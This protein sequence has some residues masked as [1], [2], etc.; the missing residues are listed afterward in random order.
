MNAHVNITAEA[1]LPVAEEAHRFQIRETVEPSDD[2]ESWF[3]NIGGI[4]VL[5]TPV[6]IAEHR[7]NVATL[8]RFEV[9]D[10]VDLH[11]TSRGHYDA[12]VLDRHLFAPGP[13]G[14]RAV[15]LLFCEGDEPHCIT[16]SEGSLE[17]IETGYW[18]KEDCQALLDRFD[19]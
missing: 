2:W 19:G 16:L 1:I 3:V 5:N 6:A 10:L 13:N 12:I 17:L 4:N 11:F 14:G 8:H 18:A 9:G 7:K 15:T